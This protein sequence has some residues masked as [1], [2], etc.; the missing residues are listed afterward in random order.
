MRKCSLRL[1]VLTTANILRR[2]TDR[3]LLSINNTDNL[4]LSNIQII[5]YIT[6]NLGKE[7]YQ[8]D[9]ENYLSLKPSTVSANL[10]LLEKKGYVIREYSTVDT[11]LKRVTP[12]Q[13]AIEIEKHMSVGAQ[14]IEDRINSILDNE[15][16]ESLFKLLD[17]LSTNFE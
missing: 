7:I 3:E 13:K 11:R 6:I 10:S 17:K 2:K 14:K 1:K 12:T 16:R 8:K 4:S 9:I 15:E 5:G